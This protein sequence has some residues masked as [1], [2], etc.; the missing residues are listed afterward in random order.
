LD[1]GVNTGARRGITSEA[2]VKSRRFSPGARLCLSTGWSLATAWSCAAAIALS[3]GCN[4][5]EPAAS[6]RPQPARTAAAAE[7]RAAPP[8]AAART[9][10]PSRRTAITALP[11]PVE[12]LPRASQELAVAGLDEVKRALGAVDEDAFA[13]LVHEEKVALPNNCV[14]WR[15]LRK[16]GYVPRKT[17]TGL[18]EQVDSGALVRCGALEF[19]ARAKPSRFSYVQ[20]AIEGA[21]PQALPA[22]VASAPSKAEQRA[23]SAA[24][25]KALTL[26]EYLPD[27]RAGQSEL[28]RRVSIIEPSSATSVIIHAE[29]W[30]DINGDEVEDLLLSVLNSSDEETYFDMRLIEVTRLSPRA[31]LTVL[32]VSE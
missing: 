31:P 23:R 7:E 10:G 22:I 32:A 1:F 13:L 17:K 3:W 18:A 6:A 21:G 8:P 29:A 9:R 14:S 5:S 15:S 4:R 26:E 28:M 30:G 11:E 16:R 27:A 19:L 20:S 24:V 12:L 25:G 2:G